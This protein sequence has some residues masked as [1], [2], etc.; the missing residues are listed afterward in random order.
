[1]SYPKL[2]HDLLF[3]TDT[4]TKLRLIAELSHYAQNN[5]SF[6]GGNNTVRG[7]M[8]LINLIADPVY[9]AEYF[10]YLGENGTPEEIQMARDQIFSPR[11]GVFQHLKRAVELHVSPASQRWDRTRREYR[12]CRE[13]RYNLINQL[14][15]DAPSTKLTNQQ[16]VDMALT[17]T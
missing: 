6:S 9:R 5:I 12:Q 2:N 17:E 3:N 1:M 4:E 8:T 13:V 16:K 11:S 14:F 10:D 7:F 15:I